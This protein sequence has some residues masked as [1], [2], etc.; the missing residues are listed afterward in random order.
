MSQEQDRWDWNW[1]ANNLFR[2]SRIIRE[3]W[4]HIICINFHFVFF[5]GN[6]RECAPPDAVLCRNFQA[7]YFY[8]I[9]VGAF[10]KELVYKGRCG[11]LLV[12]F[13]LVSN[14]SSLCHAIWFCLAVRHSFLKK[15]AIAKTV[16]YIWTWIRSA[17]SFT[18]I[19]IIN[20]S[21]TWVGLHVIRE[22]N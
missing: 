13:M 14:S 12:L 10:L 15:L 18:A 9:K 8:W 21:G 2:E 5:C 17:N 6:F 7:T 3:S 22:S 20:N 19:N 4:L 11:I 1:R 16:K